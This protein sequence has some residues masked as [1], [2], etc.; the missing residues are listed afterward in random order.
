M[1]MS[2]KVFNFQTVLMFVSLQQKAVA[3]SLQ[4]A[5]LRL[6]T[7]FELNALQVSDQQSETP[8]SV[9]CDKTIDCT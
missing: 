2:S 3:E 4:L 8:Y 1:N 7:Q 9:H 6:Q 5:A